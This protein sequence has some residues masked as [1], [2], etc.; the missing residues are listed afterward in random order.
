M[1][2]EDHKILKLKSL[3]LQNLKEDLDAEILE[4]FGYLEKLDLSNNGELF[5]Q[6]CLDSFGDF[7]FREKLLGNNAK[8]VLKSFKMKKIKN[9][10]GSQNTHN[11]IKSLTKVLI[12]QSNLSE[13]DISE[14][15][16]SCEEVWEILRYISPNVVK[17]KIWGNKFSEIQ[18]KDIFVFLTHNFRNTDEFEI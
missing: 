8:G 1:G 3:K 16:F 13:I 11:L 10:P 18:K 7:F 12:H 5:L 15:D 2:I 17:L 14:N 6:K 4:N 9:D